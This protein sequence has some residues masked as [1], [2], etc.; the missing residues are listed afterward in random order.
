LIFSRIGEVEA[1]TG[2]TSLVETDSLFARTFRRCALTFSLAAAILLDGKS[3]QGPTQTL[4][5]NGR[6][7]TCSSR[8]HVLS[9]S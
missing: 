8:T 9:S 5:T 6:E 2:C 3:D 4:G 7:R 1:A